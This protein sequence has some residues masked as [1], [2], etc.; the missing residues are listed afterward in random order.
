MFSFQKW[1]DADG[2]TA[3]QYLN[4]TAL[5]ASDWVCA[6]CPP[7]GAC[8][9]PITLN[10]LGP[11]FGW[12][13]IPH[14]QVKTPKEMFAKCIYPPA[15][16]GAPN[17]AFTKRYFDDN[18]TDLATIRFNSITNTSTTNCATHLAFRNQSR[19]C[20]MCNRTSKR[21]G[22]ARCDI[23]P[24]PA[25]TIGLMILGV[26]V[27]I[28]VVVFLVVSAIQDAGKVLVSDSIQKIL[29]NYLQVISFAQKFP[30]RWPRFLEN[31]FEFQGAI[32]T[33]GEHLLNIDC[34]STTHSAAALFYSKQAMYAFAPFIIACIAF[35]FWYLKACWSGESF[36]KRINKQDTTMKDKCILTIG[37]VVYF[38]FPTLC[39]NAFSIF[40][41]RRVAGV[42]YLAADME[43]PCYI[44]GDRHLNMVILLGISQLLAFVIG[45]PLIVL[46]FLR[47]NKLLG[48]GGLE[49]H[50]TI[51]RY[52]LFYGAYKDSTYYWEIVLTARKI[53]I[54]ALSVFGPGLGTERQ[55]QMVLAVLMICISL[56]IAGDPFKL[57][58]DRFRVLGRLEIATLFVQLA[59]M[60]SGSMIFASQDPD[61]KSFVVCL[62]VIVAILNIGMLIWLVFQ[63][64]RECVHEQKEEAA[65]KEGS[66]RGSKLSELYSDAR[67]S[68]RR[69]RF[70][71]MTPD[72]QQRVI[73][74]RTI[75]A[76]DVTTADNPVT[77]EMSTSHRARL[78]SI[79]AKREH[80]TS[81]SDQE[82]DILPPIPPRV[83]HSSPP[84]PPRQMHSINPTLGI[85][86]EDDE[87]E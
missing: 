1:K 72:A 18:E 53:L 7:G 48:E 83:Q 46:V 65:K 21:K 70:S 19:L 25:Q 47:R 2:C 75:D 87:F 35:L 32:S 78:S 64:L 61:S 27:A 6:T 36:A 33:I 29:I 23:C 74:R 80:R 56:E 68:V 20:H 57:I 71:R 41:C 66:D 9:G 37:T 13:K 58:N 24:D 77:I 39:T 62:S 44:A 16:L 54:V 22:V 4:N 69:W 51:V 10:T 59:T 42:L 79:Q 12:W 86:V 17:P 50:S 26:I 15:C 8:V 45:L 60:W 52:G 63:M 49:K 3:E 34:L 31:L 85:K 30:L 40:H 14:F 38:M 84:L 5:D 81:I 28:G 43:E 76:N 67:D 73:R 55:A 82:E 11:L